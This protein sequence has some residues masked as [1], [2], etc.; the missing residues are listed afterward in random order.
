MSI[1]NLIWNKMLFSMVWAH[2]QMF[3]GWLTLGRSGNC[4]IRN[5]LGKRGYRTNAPWNMAISERL[6]Y[7]VKIW[8]CRRKKNHRLICWCAMCITLCGDV[9]MHL[10]F[11]FYA[12]RNRCWVA[13]EC[14][15][16]V[17]NLSTYVELSTNLNLIHRNVNSYIRPWCRLIY[18][19]C[20]STS[21]QRESFLRHYRWRISFIHSYGIVSG[22]SI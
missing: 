20:W 13:A 14:L 9:A 7:V 4:T 18:V 21:A 1:A 8:E 15:M 11:A 5:S 22:E 6:V 3:G 17:T 2:R 19:C 12:V 16:R 10:P